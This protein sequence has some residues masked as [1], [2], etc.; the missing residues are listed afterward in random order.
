MSAV[1]THRR[2][3]GLLT[4]VVS[5]L[6]FVPLLVLGAAIGWPGSLGD[7]AEVALPRLLDHESATRLGYLAYLTYSV[8]FFPVAVSI[9]MWR[10][11]TSANLTC[12]LGIAI[13]A[14]AVSALARGIGI[15]RWLSAAFP[16]AERWQHSTSEATREALAVQFETLDDFA[17]AIGETLGVS[18][19]AAVWLGATIAGPGLPR[20]ARITGALTL[21][22]LA[23]P[24]IEL[25]GVDAE[26]S[27]SLS[28]TAITIW[29]FAVGVAMM[30]DRTD[31]NI[32]P[33]PAGSPRSVPMSSPDSDPGDK[34]GPRSR[35]QTL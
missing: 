11:E 23:A 33:S 8:A 21:V 28:S 7:P 9:S 14:A 29:L 26:A 10:R 16:L 15:T 13:G 6:V 25:A 3:R 22:A 5:L 19:F 31:G 1:P 24:A 20:W 12:A 27:V 35:P 2:T 17:G 4:I 34:V 18:I 30:R 32:S